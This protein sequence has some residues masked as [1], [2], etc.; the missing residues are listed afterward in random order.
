MYQKS[1][2]IPDGAKR[3]LGYNGVVTYEQ[4]KLKTISVKVEDY[5]DSS[6]TRKAKLREDPVWLVKI[7]LI[8]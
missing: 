3:L 7:K 5:G 4:A 2:L 1:R 6:C 8:N